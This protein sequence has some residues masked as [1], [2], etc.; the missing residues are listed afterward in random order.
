M[1]SNVDNIK[2]RIRGLLTLGNDP[3]AFEAEASNALRFAARL[4]LKH[5]ISEAELEPTRDVHEQAADTE[6]S[7]METPTAG[8][9]L[10]KWESL[11]AWAMVK[12]VGT[13]QHYIGP[14]TIRR[15]NG[16]VELDPETGETV[17]STPIMFYGPLGDATEA[18]QMFLEWSAT[19][20][21]MARLRYGGAFRG[22][23]R[24][25][26][27]GFAR[28]LYDRALEITEQ[29]TALLS[30]GASD[31]YAL[32]IQRSQD[33]VRAH[34]LRGREWLFETHNIKL[35]RRSGC[36]GSSGQHF[37]EAYSAGRADG[38]RSGF[39]RTGG[40]RMLT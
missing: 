35:S 32:V 27:E 12:L 24:S 34:I 17:R 21:A 33:L 5:Q 11:L 26:C 2:A 15:R 14:Q 6:Y 3:G 30:E 4:M 7:R 10:S 38:Q 20:I 8:V 39:T 18:Q 37:G 29:E 16:V 40:R 13:V 22:E 1:S 23:G 9:R 25:Y 19:I 36:N 31:E 28:A